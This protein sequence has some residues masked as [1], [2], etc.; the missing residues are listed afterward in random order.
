M[1]RVCRL[2]PDLPSIVLRLPRAI[3]RSPLHGHPDVDL[4]GRVDR[5]DAVSELEGHVFLSYLRD[6][7]LG[8]FVI[9][10]VPVSR[11]TDVVDR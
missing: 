3:A 7:Y 10:V 5:Y 1:V 9:L 4:V 6:C 2:V 11:E 8:G